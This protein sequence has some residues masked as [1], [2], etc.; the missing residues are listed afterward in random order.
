M[1]QRG[2]PLDL[3]VYISPVM[4]GFDRIRIGPVDSIPPTP[5]VFL[6]TGAW[7][8]TAVNAPTTGVRSS[9]GVGGNFDF[10]GEGSIAPPRDCK[11]TAA[12]SLRQPASRHRCDED[13][14]SSRTTGRPGRLP[15]WL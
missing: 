12:I 11:A 7:S 13:A 3:T 9:S 8:E 14:A 4:R 2:R 1:V 5:P 6:V 15:H 10:A